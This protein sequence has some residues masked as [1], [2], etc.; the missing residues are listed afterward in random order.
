MGERERATHLDGK[1]QPLYTLY[2]IAYVFCGILVQLTGIAAREKLC[3][4]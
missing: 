4:I 2:G 3:I 1:L